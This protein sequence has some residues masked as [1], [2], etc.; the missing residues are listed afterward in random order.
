MDPALAWLREIIT[1]VAA[2]VDRT[3]AAQMKVG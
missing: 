3:P 1:D 2:E